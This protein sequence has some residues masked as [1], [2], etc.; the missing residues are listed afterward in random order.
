M[1]RHQT[2]VGLW[3]KMIYSKVMEIIF[4]CENNFSIIDN[5]V[6]LTEIN[7]KCQI[8]KFFQN[9]FIIKYNL[10]ESQIK[11]FLGF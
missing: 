8:R 11:L 4:L 7:T 9:L 1:S 6:A 3:Y 5:A 2:E 10:F